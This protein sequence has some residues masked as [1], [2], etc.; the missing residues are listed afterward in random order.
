MRKKQLKE[1]IISY[2]GEPSIQMFNGKEYLIFDNTEDLSWK[3]LPNFTLGELLTKNK[4]DSYTKL[5]LD[6]LIE[7]Q[8]FRDL[9]GSGIGVSSSYRS[10]A[11]N[12][13]TNGATSSEHINGNALDTYPING[14]ILGYKDIIR[15]NKK[16]GGRGYY[17]T[18]VHIDTGRTRVW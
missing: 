16:S 14:D 4:I 9:W 3:V 6:L 17:R 1:R 8:T 5:D 7:L 13:S 18:F 11:Y 10:E 2:L 12:R 15:F